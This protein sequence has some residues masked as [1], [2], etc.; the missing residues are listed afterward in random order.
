MIKKI[1]QG[2]ESV[3]TFAGEV[4]AELKKCSWPDRTELLDSTVVVIISVALLGAYV[5]DSDLVVMNALK[6]L[7]K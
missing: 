4:R 7:L 3:K 6:L 2:I 1:S 5:G